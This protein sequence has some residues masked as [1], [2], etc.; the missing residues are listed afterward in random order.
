MNTTLA[1]DTL[2]FATR[3]ENAGAPAAQAK[4]QA[5]VLREVFDERDQALAIVQALL[6]EARRDAEHAASRS[7][8]FATR[9]DISGVRTELAE[10]KADVAVIKTE[11]V[12]VKADVAGIKTELAEVKADVAVIK[13]ELAEVKA[14]VAGIKTE[15]AGVKIDVALLHKEIE[16]VDQRSQ[17]RFK[18]L[19]WMFGGLIAALF[20]V[21]AALAPAALRVYFGG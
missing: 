16:L 13:T 21:S 19:Y 3:L 6:N 17:S 2:K 8:Q 9:T 15:L 12:E 20:A 18:L 10:V 14:D 4:A 5:E 11:L 7:E 1:F